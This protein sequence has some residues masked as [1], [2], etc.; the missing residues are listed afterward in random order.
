MLTAALARSSTS[1]AGAYNLLQSGFNIVRSGLFVVGPLDSRLRA[2]RDYRLARLTG[3]EKLLFRSRE[4]CLL[5]CLEG[6]VQ[7]ASAAFVLELLGEYLLVK[8]ELGRTALRSIEVAL[9]A[10]AVGAETQLAPGLFSPLTRALLRQ[11]KVCDAMDS[12]LEVDL[13]AVRT[14]FRSFWTQ[15]QSDFRRDFAKRFP[16]G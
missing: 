13:S 16:S 14:G 2:Q 11:P 4:Q 10:H 9:F 1:N 6:A 3:D 15:L 5:A 8:T 12:I 7:I